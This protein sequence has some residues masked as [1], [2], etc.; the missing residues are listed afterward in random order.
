MNASCL[1]RFLTAWAALLAT[2]GCGFNT[3]RISDLSERDAPRSNKGIVLI[4]AGYYKKGTLITKIFQDVHKLISRDALERQLYLANRK[5]TRTE[6][7]RLSLYFEFINKY[8]KRNWLDMSVTFY[9]EDGVA[10]ETSDWEVKELP[11]MVKTAYRK[12][13][14]SGTAVGYELYVRDY[15]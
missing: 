9:D 3:G 8:G 7:G 12:S 2:Y 13:S 10:I 1:F 4:D 6:D 14:L 11:K 15:R 5:V